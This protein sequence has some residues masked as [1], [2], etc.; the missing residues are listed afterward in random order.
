MLRNQEWA[1]CGG[2]LWFAGLVCEALGSLRSCE[3]VLVPALLD[4]LEPAAAQSTSSQQQRIFE[5]IG[6]LPEH[7]RARLLPALETR[8]QI[9][10][11]NA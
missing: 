11:V 6:L 3:D 8:W 10:S 7:L 1:V 4:L 5:R 9:P 2:Q